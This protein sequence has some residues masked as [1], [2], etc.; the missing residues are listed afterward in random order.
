TREI[1]VQRRL[2]L[3]VGNVF[4]AC[5]LGED[6][7]VVEQQIEPPE[8]VSD[9]LEQTVHALRV[10]D[11]RRLH[12]ATRAQALAFVR[13]LLQGLAATSGERQVEAV[14]HYREGN[15]LADAGTCAG[16]QREFSLT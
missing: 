9:P 5:E 8:V 1:D 14:A 10:A 6:P 2:P 7:R 4:N 12:Q 16:H 13:S 11:V 3:F 15:M